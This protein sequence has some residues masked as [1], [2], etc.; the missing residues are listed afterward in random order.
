LMGMALWLPLIRCFFSFFRIEMAQSYGAFFLVSALF[1]LAVTF[2]GIAISIMMTT[3][4]KAT[5]VLM[6]IATPSFIIS[7]QTW[8]LSQMPHAIQYIADFIPLTHYLEAF[9]SLLM[10]KASY[11][12]IMPQITSLSVLT[13]INMIIAYFALRYRVARTKI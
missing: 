8:P 3:Q 1:M 2:L 10:Y 4:L 6:I 5:E 7:G 11:K 12:Q 13:V 9:R